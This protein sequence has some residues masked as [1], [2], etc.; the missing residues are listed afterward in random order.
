[1]GR[2]I[3]L[4][5]VGCYGQPCHCHL[6]PTAPGLAGNGGRAAEGARSA[7]VDPTQRPNRRSGPRALSARSE[8]RSAASAASPATEARTIRERYHA[9]NTIS[10]PD[11]EAQLRLRPRI[12]EVALRARPRR[13]LGSS[14][15]LKAPSG[16][17]ASRGQVAAGA[18]QPAMYS[19]NAGSAALHQRSYCR[20][21]WLLRR[22]NIRFGFCVAR[23]IDA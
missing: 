1:M 22:R 21:C 4:G 2:A 14:I 13:C 23:R 10:P 11:L 16:R 6:Y 8:F 7:S 9:D 12:W 5:V 17:G 18:S 19:R 3:R 20:R 15:E